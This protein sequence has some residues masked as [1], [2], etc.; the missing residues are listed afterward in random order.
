M[1]CL[2]T[3]EVKE[4]ASKNPVYFFSRD[5]DEQTTINISSLAKISSTSS[6]DKYLGTPSL[7]GRIH[8]G[9]FRQLRER[10][11]ER[12]DGWKAKHLSLAGRN[13]RSI[14]SS[15]LFFFLWGSSNE[16]KKVHLLN[17]DSV[18]GGLGIKRMRNVNLAFM[19][20]LGWRL[21]SELKEK[22]L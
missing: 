8:T 12:L 1:E 21:L 11:E 9:L 6:L 22:K 5:V 18:T 7:T 13:A 20:K 16:G 19:A 14:P 17:W 3:L 10:I 2:N 15:Q 4:S